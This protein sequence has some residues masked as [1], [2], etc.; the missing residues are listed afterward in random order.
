MAF[1]DSRVMGKKRFTHLTSGI[2]IIYRNKIHII[3]LTSHGASQTI[4][5]FKCYLIAIMRF[6][7]E[8]KDGD[9]GYFSMV[10]VQYTSVKEIKECRIEITVPTLN[11]G[12]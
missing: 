12:I 5:P 7:A 4:I 9:V 11:T 2:V 1:L 3:P 10:I 6:L 8:L